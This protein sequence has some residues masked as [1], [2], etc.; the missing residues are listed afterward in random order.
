MQPAHPQSHY[1]A[2]RRGRAR[3]GEREEAKTRSTHAHERTREILT[4]LEGSASPKLAIMSR[5]VR[6]EPV[7]TL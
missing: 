2:P 1:K 4:T 7:L 3:V 6:M 5:I